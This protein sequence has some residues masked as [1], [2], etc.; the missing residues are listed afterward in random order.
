MVGRAGNP[1]LY[2]LSGHQNSG[3]RGTLAVH[4]LRL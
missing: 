3:G 4:P 1:K 2:G